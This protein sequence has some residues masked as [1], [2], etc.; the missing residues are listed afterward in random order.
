VVSSLPP[1]TSLSSQLAEVRFRKLYADHRGEIL[2]FALRRVA[3]PED[4]ADVLAETF[5]VAWRRLD[6]LPPQSQARFWLIGVARRALANQRRGEDRR[7]RLVERLRTELAVDLARIR[8]ETPDGGEVLAALET[9]HPADQELLRLN[10]WEGLAP[11][12]AALVLGISSVAARSRLHRARRRLRLV[13]DG[14]RTGFTGRET[15]E[16]REEE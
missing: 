4:A 15:L 7:S 12:E 16:P 11:T 13:L 14:R 9:L 3:D 5:L 8:V 10:A 6:D 1:D 2:A